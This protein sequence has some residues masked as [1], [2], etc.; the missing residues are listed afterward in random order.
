[1]IL[2][3]LIRESQTLKGRI[4]QEHAVLVDFQRKNPWTITNILDKMKEDGMKKVPTFEQILI[5][6]E[7]FLLD[8]LSKIYYQI[9]K[10]NPLLIVREF[11]EKVWFYSVQDDLFKTQLAEGY[12][13]G[14]KDKDGKLVS[15]SNLIIETATIDIKEF[16]ELYFTTLN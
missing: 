6:K 10:I 2:L 12:H 9:K 7:E 14:D 3:E 5:L 13:L 16:L 4:K 11:P 1:M 8:D 15:G